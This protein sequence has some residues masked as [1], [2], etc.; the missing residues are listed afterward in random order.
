MHFDT[1]FLIIIIWSPLRFQSGRP[2][3]RNGSIVHSAM[4]RRA[5]MRCEKFMK[6]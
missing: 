3:A 2:A 4:K 5:I 1:D 6:L